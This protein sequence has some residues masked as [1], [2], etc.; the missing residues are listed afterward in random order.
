MATLFIC[1][2]IVNNENNDGLICSD[3]LSMI[4]SSA[5]YAICNFEA[6]ISGVGQP[7]VKTGPHLNQHP[8]TIRGLK[9]Q[10]FDLLLLANNHIMDFG[11]A[12]LKHTLDIA[13]REAFETIGAGMDSTSAYK[14]LIKNIDGISFGFINACESQFGVIDNFKRDVLSGYAWINDYRIDNEI[15]S[16]KNQCDFVIVF[17]HAGIEHYP[18]PQQRWRQKYR[19]FCDLGADIIVGGHTHVAQ[20]FEEYHKSTIFYSLGN[21]YF[22]SLH[23]KYTEDSSFALKIEINKNQPVKFQPVFH[24]THKNK[25]DIAPVSK[26]VNLKELNEMLNNNYQEYQDKMCLEIYKK[27]KPRLLSSLS[28]VP[29]VGTLKGSL[30]KLFTLIFKRQ[31]I[32][33]NDLLLLILIR[34]ESCHYAVKHALEL[35]V[36]KKF[37]HNMLYEKEH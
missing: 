31:K 22:D 8:N 37:Q 18:I 25:V 2:D 5:D 15:I 14:S 13:K 21:F 27:L 34:N 20:G 4:I 26:H 9:Q 24:Y 3:E 6:P 33:D 12:A 30:K 10:G 17:S 23:Y 36:K 1:G 32:V 35:I 28:P 11:S 19:H 16:L 7:Q 29:F